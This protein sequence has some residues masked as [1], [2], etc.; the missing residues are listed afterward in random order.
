MR[1]YTGYPRFVGA[2]TPGWDIEMMR[3]ESGLGL[4]RRAE[5][6]V[7]SVKAFQMTV[8]L[9]DVIRASL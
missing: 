5:M 8:L 7:G 1:K 9:G 6:S 2:L 4:N 3:L